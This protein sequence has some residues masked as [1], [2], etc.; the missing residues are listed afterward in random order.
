M[1]H[2]G[3]FANIAVGQ[4][5][6]V[7]DQ[8]A[9][10][11]SDYHVTES[12]FGADIGFENSEYQV[13]LKRTCS[14]LRRDCRHCQGAQDAWRAKSRTG[15]ALDEAYTTENVGLVEKDENLTGAYRDC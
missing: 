14:Q 1:V 7:A 15:K 3:P 8:V 2:A 5:S 13:P 12:G 6:I 10:K 11:L 4:S 9:L